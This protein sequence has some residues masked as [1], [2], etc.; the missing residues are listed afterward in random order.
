MLSEINQAE[1]Y[2]Y[3]MISLIRGF[4]KK[5]K[6]ANKSNENKQTK[7]KATLIDTEN[8]LVVAR[9]NGWRV[10]ETGEGSQWFKLPVIK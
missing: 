10:G 7:K 1:K 3:H 5:Q 2:K 9:G 8:R 4:F 6:K